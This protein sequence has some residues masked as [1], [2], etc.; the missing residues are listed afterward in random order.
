MPDDAWWTRLLPA[1]LSFFLITLTVAWLARSR[2]RSR[3]DEGP[4]LMRL[5]PYL[6]VIGIA[7]TL[8]NWAIGCFSMVYLDA[9]GWLFFNGLI[10][11]GGSLIF[12]WI[13][14]EYFLAWNHIEADGLRY[15][16]LFGRPGFLLWRDVTRLSYSET[17]GAFRLERAGG[18]VVGVSVLQTALTE[19]AKAAVANIPAA[20]IDSEARPIV[21]R[22]AAG[23]SPPVWVGC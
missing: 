7:G 23:G 12:V 11:F 2:S 22:T 4:T 16:P 10:F 14:A 1:L 8:F 13:V 9:L 17:S 6:L 18:A 3:P 21:E 20:R 19:F 5:P 15:R